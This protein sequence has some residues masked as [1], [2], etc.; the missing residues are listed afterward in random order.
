MASQVKTALRN[1]QEI[2]DEGFMTQAEYNARRKAIIDGATAIEPLT[3]DPA[4]QNVSDSSVF[5]RLG[6]RP[7]GESSTKQYSGAGARA[8]GGKGVSDLRS[9]L[10]KPLAGPKPAISKTDRTDLRAVVNKATAHVAGVARRGN[11]RNWRG[12]GRGLGRGG[13]GLPEKCPW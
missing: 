7:D 4:K 3:N 13:R 12:A 5:S 11:G 6:S 2:F 9:L 1:L 10:S 8:R